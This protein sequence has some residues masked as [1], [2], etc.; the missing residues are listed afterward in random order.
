MSSPTVSFTE[1]IL[2]DQPISPSLVDGWKVQAVMEA[3]KESN[4]TGRRAAVEA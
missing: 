3:A 2:D 1:A 4:Q